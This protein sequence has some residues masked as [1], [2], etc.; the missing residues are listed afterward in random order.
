MRLTP[1]ALPILSHLI[2][3][4]VLHTVK[5]QDKLELHPWALY[6]SWTLAKVALTKYLSLLRNRPL[7]SS[8]DVMEFAVIGHCV[9]VVDLTISLLMVFQAWWLEC[10]KSVDSTV[11]VHLS[12]RL[13]L[14]LVKRLFAAPFLAL[15][16]SASL[17]MHSRSSLFFYILK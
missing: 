10:V 3:N 4:P 9:V 15:L 13:S 8:C 2:A 6:S 5:L 14:S 12:L 7:L 1:G 11:S 16:V 17:W